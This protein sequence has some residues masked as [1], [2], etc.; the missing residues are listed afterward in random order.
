[1]AIRKTPEKRAPAWT[2][3]VNPQA[4]SSIGAGTRQ[5]VMIH[6]YWSA[7]GDA[8]DAREGGRGHLMQ[9][10]KVTADLGLDAAPVPGFTEAEMQTITSAAKIAAIKCLRARARRK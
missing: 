10:D 4:F 3:K 9:R 6:V 5:E 7:R 2:K 1:M 8:R